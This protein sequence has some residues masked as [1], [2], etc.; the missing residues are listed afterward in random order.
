MKHLFLLSLLAINA[1]SYSMELWTK[2]KI[3]FLTAYK[4]PSEFMGESSASPSGVSQK[5]KPL[6]STPKSKSLVEYQ[7]TQKQ[8]ING[9]LGSLFAAGICKYSANQY[10]PQGDSYFNLSMASGVCLGVSATFA[11]KLLTTPAPK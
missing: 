6:P 10:H 7:R 4:D 9:F 8:N 2:L 5:S 1:N 3:K 11:Y